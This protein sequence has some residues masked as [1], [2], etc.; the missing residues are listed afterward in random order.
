MA[1]IEGASSEYDRVAEVYAQLRESQMLGHEMDWLEKGHSQPR[2][3]LDAG[4]GPG[5]DLRS[6][7]RRGNFVIGL[8]LS[9]KMLSIASENNSD[10][11]G[12][13][14]IGL[15]RGDLSRIPLND[16]SIDAIW[17][18]T[19]LPH[20]SAT[21]LTV[22]FKEFWRI[23]REDGMLVCSVKLGIGEGYEAEEQLDNALRYM[24]YW[25]LDAFEKL[26]LQLGFIR[27]D[28]HLWNERLRFPEVG[29]DIEF[30]SLA[31]KLTNEQRG[32]DQ[33]NIASRH[34]SRRCDSRG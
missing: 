32:I 25:D 26:A 3:I 21:I 15:V 4:C 33:A 2:V 29:R 24:R 11:I 23:L 10:L 12:R 20:F 22:V 28:L 5:R 31:L 14:Q 34:C 7:R 17:C 27:T 30:A 13:D 1:A 19:V 6:L 8:D 18:S 16:S 9:E